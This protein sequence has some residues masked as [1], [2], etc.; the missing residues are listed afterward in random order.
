MNKGWLVV[1]KQEMTKIW[2]D[3]KF[4]PVTIVKV[5]PQEIVRYKTSEKD[6]Y[7]AVVVGVEKKEKDS[8]KW[9][10][11]VY[12]DSVEFKVDLDYVQN[13]QIGKT[14]D[15]DMIQW[16]ESVDVTV[17]ISKG[18]GFQGMV[19]RCNIKVWNEQLM[20]INLQELE[21]QREIENQEEH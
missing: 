11:V 6:G 15:V 4:V 3:D 14:F 10:K 19:K 2:V 7:T 1:K 13:N 5:V 17:G 21:V 16:N 9:K 18:K 12:K 20:V 8:K